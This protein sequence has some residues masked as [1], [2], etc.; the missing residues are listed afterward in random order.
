MPFRDQWTTADDTQ[1]IT[2]MQGEAAKEPMRV[3]ICED[4]TE[5]PVYNNLLKD[6]IREGLPEIRE[7]SVLM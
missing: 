2:T 6:L 5:A 4:L 1:R 7:C 3:R